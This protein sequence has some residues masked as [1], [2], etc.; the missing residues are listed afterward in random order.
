MKS[1][2]EIDIEETPIIILGCGHFFTAETLDSHMGMGDIYIIDGY[3]EFTELRDTAQL[4]C[5][6]PCCLDC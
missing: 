6:I 2:N 3:G 1:Y 5:S 4:V